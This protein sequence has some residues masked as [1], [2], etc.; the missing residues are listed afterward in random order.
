M[1]K[2]NV[3]MTVG[4]AGTPG[5]R[6]SVAALTVEDSVLTMVDRR[7]TGL[8]CSAYRS[9]VMVGVTSTVSTRTTFMVRTERRM[10]TA[11]RKER[12]IPSPFCGNLRIVVQ[13]G[14]K[15]TS[16]SLPSKRKTR[17]RAKTETAFARRML[18]QRT[19]DVRLKTNRPSLDRPVPFARRT[20]EDS[21]RF[22]LK[23]E[24]RTEVRMLL[25]GSPAQRWVRRTR[26]SVVRVDRKVFN[27][28]FLNAPMLRN[29]KVSTTFGQDERE[30]LLFRSVLS[31]RM[32]KDFIML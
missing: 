23:K 17:K 25:K 6:E 21:M 28:R 20:T 26:D 27:K 22:V 29:R 2:D 32:T 1:K 24:E 11:V 9:V 12:N 18:W 31:W 16:P 13:L 30:T 5:T 14:L 19:A 10:A 4:F 7:T 15:V 8:R 3:M